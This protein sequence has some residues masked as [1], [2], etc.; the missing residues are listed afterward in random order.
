GRPMSSR[1]SETRPTALGFRDDRFRPE[2]Q[3]LRAV[4]VLLVIAYHFFPGRV[5]GGF[6]GVDVFFV[7]SGF[8]II[9]HLRDGF[10]RDGR[11]SLPGFWARRARRLLPASLL[12]LAVTALGTVAFIPASEW[13]QIFREIAA[14]AA[15]VQNWRLAADSVDYLNAE[16]APS[17]VQHFW[18]LSVEEQFYLVVP[19]VLVLAALIGRRV[20]PRHP[21]GPL[22]ITL[23]LIV[24]VSLAFSVV[25][26]AIAP[27]PAYFVTPT[28]AWEFAAGGLLAFGIARLERMPSV[29]RALVA[30][31]GWAGIVASALLITGSM[32]FPGWIAILPVVATL[33]V[34]GAG[35]PEVRWAPDRLLAQRPVIALGDISYSVYLWHWPLLIFAQHLWGPELPAWL[36]LA[37]LVPVIVL[38]WATTRFVENPV[39]RARVLTTRRPRVTF[40]A[41]V[42]AMAV[43]IVPSL[44]AA[45]AVKQAAEDELRQAAE[46]IATSGDC[47][48]AGLREP[49]FDC[50]PRE[51][52]QL[53]PD[54]SAAVDDKSPFYDNGC[55]MK[56]LQAGMRGCSAGVPDGT[57]RVLLI[58]DSHAVHWLPALERVA[59]DRDWAITTHFR[60]GCPYS[61]RMAGM[62]QVC[63]DWNTDVA[64]A[65]AAEQPYDLVIVSDKVKVGF[66]PN[67]DVAVEGFREAWQPLIDRG[68]QVVVIRDTPQTPKTTTACLQAHETDPDAC[69]VPESEA[70]PAPDYQVQ[71]ADGMPHVHV[72]DLTS[73]FCWDGTCKQAIGGVVTYRDTHHITE[74]LSSTFGPV[75]ERRLDGLGL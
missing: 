70:F 53:I 18:S 39:R 31:A 27:G 66:W 74:T 46:I 71:A 33:A 16:N 29:I 47:I 44:G 61:T 5:S 36:K 21:R 48:G 54:P 52:A 28:R 69:A 43:V 51:F 10:A 68:A 6:I 75:I 17:P 40:A 12:V 14:S 13:V 24:A 15:Y 57:V 2:V 59:Q 49:E 72:I 67:A 22:V 19:L 25:L 32:P 3:V 23:V 37:V 63:T 58:G 62:S 26:T 34:I 55:I 20:A 38:A 64:A 11:I 35:R 9:S 8:L 65:L 1:A 73:S 60:S 45:A 4:A 7:V 30:W 56:L 41:V 42:V 50:A